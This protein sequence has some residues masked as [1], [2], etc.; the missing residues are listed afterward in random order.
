M[1][2]D[3][4][5]LAGGHTEPAL[6]EMTGTGRRA[7][8]PFEGKPFIAWVMEALRDC[9]S[10]ERIAVVGPKELCGTPVAGLA[11]LVVPEATGIFENFCAGIE[12][13][14][15]AGKVL[16]MASDNPLLSARALEDFLGR[17][18]EAD[19]CYPI[20][21]GEV[22]RGQRRDASRGCGKG[23]AKYGGGA[24]HI[25]SCVRAC[26]VVPWRRGGVPGS[27]TPFT[28]RQIRLYPE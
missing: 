6:A 14:G 1:N 3:A 23:E 24:D 13:L 16:V 4:V 15:S 27:S 22:D 7:L 5:V 21:R 20:L 8:I 18:P 11:D 26:P 2:T 19:V 10:V 25:V 17:C 12:A 28:A 9:A